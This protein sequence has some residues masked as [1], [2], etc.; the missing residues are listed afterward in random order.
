MWSSIWKG[1]ISEVY[2]LFLLF[3]L[4][5][6]TN[7]CAQDNPVKELTYYATED[8]KTQAPPSFPG[9]HQELVLFI[10]NELKHS[11]DKVNLRR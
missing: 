1:L 2:G 6:G 11:P 4:L 3:N 7:V 8:V 9:G 10:R 5:T